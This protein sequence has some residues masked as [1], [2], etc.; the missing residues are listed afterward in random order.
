MKIN[1]TK[2]HLIGTAIGF[3]SP[4]VFLPIV[5]FILALI[6]DYPFSFFWDQFVAYPE[7]TSKYISLALISNLMWFYIFLNKEE[8]QISRGIIFAMF[9]FIPYMIYVNLLS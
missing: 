8:Y 2:K 5:L 1:I 6:N 7:F 3:I 9:C 4:V